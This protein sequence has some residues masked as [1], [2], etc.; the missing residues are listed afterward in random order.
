MSENKGLL[1]IVTEDIGLT[2]QADMLRNPKYVDELITRLVSENP[3]VAK[4]L[5]DFALSNSSPDGPN[6]S[7]ALVYD[8][9]TK[10]G[11]VPKVH[12]DIDAAV[13][14]ELSQS[15]GNEYVVGMIQRL[16][17]DNPCV[18]NF[19]SQLALKTKDPITTAYAGMLVYRLLESQAQADKMKTDF[20]L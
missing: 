7:G 18:A 17:D 19:V 12:G 2:I 4:F 20:K 1:P 3:Q 13:Q 16:Q 15:Q 10:K 11:K 5:A 8:M 9:L 6:Y 14:A